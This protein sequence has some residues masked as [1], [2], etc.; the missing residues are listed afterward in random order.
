MKVYLTIDRVDEATDP[1]LTELYKQ[2]VKISENLKDVI[3]KW[4]KEMGEK[5]P[6]H[7]IIISV[8]DTEIPLSR[9]R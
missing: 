4:K 8:K 6:R 3:K 5:Y 9:R 2:S 1:E 7:I